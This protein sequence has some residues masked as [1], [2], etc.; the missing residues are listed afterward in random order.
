MEADPKDHWQ[1]LFDKA[2][3]RW[4][5][6]N[7]QPALVR[8]TKV[9]GKVELM[10]PGGVKA[11][12]PVLTFS[13]VKGKIEDVKPLVLNVTNG[14]AIAEIHGVRPSEWPGKEIVLYQGT[15]RL[16]GKEVPAI[17]IRKKKESK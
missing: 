7:G 4:F 17:R 5:H 15:Q 10:L 14:N 12:K 6:L 16:K 9:E 8:I 13:Q 2:Y 11:K 3:L 1:A